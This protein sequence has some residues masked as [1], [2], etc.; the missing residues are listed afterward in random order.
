VTEPLASLIGRGTRIDR[1]VA[2]GPLIMMKN[3]AGATRPHGIKTIVSLNTVMV[4]GTGMCGSC[5]VSVAG[6]TRFACVDGPE[7]DASDVDFD[8]MLS[9]GRIYAPEE[10]AAREAY[11]HEKDGEPLCLQRR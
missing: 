4:D 9:R 5:R 1:V 3:V 7:F 10:G 6:K 11:L 8:E 2:V